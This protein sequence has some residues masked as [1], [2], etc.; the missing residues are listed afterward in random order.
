MAAD[1]HP[2]KKTSQ[3]PGG[4][5]TASNESG[6]KI[7]KQISEVSVPIF[8]KH[9]ILGGNTVRRRKEGIQEQEKNSFGSGPSESSGFSS[10]SLTRLGEKRE[11]HPDSVPPHLSH[12]LQSSLAVRN[13]ILILAV[14]T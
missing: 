2:F 12:F 4:C 10:Y 1:H 9:L 5:P 7:L 6:K 14:E 8:P 11:R 3:L 13:W